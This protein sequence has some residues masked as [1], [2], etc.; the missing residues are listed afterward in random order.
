MEN[1]QLVSLSRQLS[2]RRELDVIA[3]NVANMTTTGFKREAILY[4]EIKNPPA[5]VNTFQ[6]PDRP[7]SFVVDWASMHDLSEGAIDTTNNPTD[8]AIRG[9]ENV[10]LV[11]QTPGGERYTRSGALQI[12]AA[13]ALVT[14]DG[15]PVL[16][17]G[18]PIQFGPAERNLTIARDGTISTNEGLRG[19]LRLARFENRQSLQKE[20]QNL[21]S[22]TVP[23]QTADNRVSIMQGSLERSNVKPVV[24]ISRM[25]ELSRAYDSITQTVQRTDELRRTAI[26]RLGRVQSS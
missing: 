2:L 15:H 10:F 12:N 9:D 11:V 25:I 16:G 23:A 7:V 5:R 22:A 14:H 8:V 4:Q 17:D 3:N 6:N 18:G 1:A 20:G 19:R 26:E 24:E 21:F 13:G